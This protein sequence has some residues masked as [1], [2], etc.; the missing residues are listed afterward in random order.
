QLDG[1]Q[2]GLMAATLDRDETGNLIRKAGVM[3]VVLTDGE[4]RPDDPIRVELPPTPHQ[5]LAPV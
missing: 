4:V 1:I 2:P 3:S 5:R